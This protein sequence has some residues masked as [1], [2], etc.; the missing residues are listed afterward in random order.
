MIF[1][2]IIIKKEFKNKNPTSEEDKERVLNIIDSLSLMVSE[3]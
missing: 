1:Y 3:K 2:K